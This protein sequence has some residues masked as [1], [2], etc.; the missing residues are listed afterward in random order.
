MKEILK[1]ITAISLIVVIWNLFWIF[2]TWVT[3]WIFPNSLFMDMLLDYGTQFI[4]I[5]DIVIWLSLFLI[6]S[7]DV[8][9]GNYLDTE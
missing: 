8:K 2:T 4:I 7:H 6:S 3:F 1:Y 5:S 9:K